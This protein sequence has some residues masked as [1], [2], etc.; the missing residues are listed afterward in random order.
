MQ[1]VAYF[2]DCSSHRDVVQISCGL[3][4]N[5]IQIIRIQSK[6]LEYS[7]RKELKG[8]MHAPDAYHCALDQAEG[9]EDLDQKVHFAS[10][11][12]SDLWRKQKPAQL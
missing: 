1:V 7:K 4:Q 5:H 8:N 11:A 3:K 12:S 6:L 10:L 2:N 9:F